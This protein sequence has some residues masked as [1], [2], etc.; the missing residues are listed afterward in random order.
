[1]P[2]QKEIEHRIDVLKVINYTVS[3]DI[4]PYHTDL[5]E[6]WDEYYA[7]H[8]ETDYI[9]V[10]SDDESYLRVLHAFAAINLRFV[11]S[12]ES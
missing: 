7:M 6:E 2:T 4:S 9:D 8:D 12:L 10:A 3:Q 5:Q 1:M 11:S